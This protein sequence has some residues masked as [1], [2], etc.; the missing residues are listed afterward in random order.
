M[1]RNKFASSHFISV[2]F[3][4]QF[5]DML[6]RLIGDSKFA[7]GVDM[8][9][10]CCVSVQGVPK[11]SW[12]RLQLP[13]PCDSEKQLIKA[14]HHTFFSWW[15]TIQKEFFLNCQYFFNETAFM[16]SRRDWNCA[17]TCSELIKLSYVVPADSNL[18]CTLKKNCNFEV[19]TCCLFI[20]L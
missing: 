14:I 1:Q 9:V 4:P 13:S 12:D 16:F 5:K 15:T 2:G 7:L 10:C 8:S 11:V 6:V 20:L 19:H 17:N 3:L 18:V